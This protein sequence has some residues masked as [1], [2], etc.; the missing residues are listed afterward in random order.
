MRKYTAEDGLRLLDYL[1]ITSLMPVERQE[2]RLKWDERY[3]EC[4][5]DPMQAT[6]E[7]YT[8]VLP[9]N[10]QEKTRETLRLNEFRIEEFMGKANEKNVRFLASQGFTLDE[11][12]D[13]ETN[14]VV[15]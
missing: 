9:I 12:L 5:S 10:C 11:I 7:L 14:G 3:K 2:F 6:F 4:E 8:S 13:E 1:E 15:N